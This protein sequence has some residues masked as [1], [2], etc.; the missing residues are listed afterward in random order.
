[1]G[2][3]EEIIKRSQ[4]HLQ[5]LFHN[6][7][8]AFLLLDAERHILAFNPTA[9][10]HMRALSGQELQEGDFIDFFFGEDDLHQVT[11]HLDQALAGENVVEER[12]F[13]GKTGARLWLE[14]SF[15]PVKED[16]APAPFGV[17]LSVVDI[18]ARMRAI[19]ALKEQN[20]KMAR[21]L[22]CSRALAR[23]AEASL[24]GSDRQ[25]ILKSTLGIAGDT[26]AADRAVIYDVDFARGH[27]MPLCEW[28]NPECTQIGRK[29]AEFALDTFKSAVQFMAVT[30]GWMQSHA[31]DPDQRLIDDGAS[32]LLHEEMDIKSLLWYP[33]LF[34]N[35]GF[36]LL[37]L[38]QVRAPR[39]WR[40]L[41][42]E[43]LDACARL[44]RA[45][46][47]RIDTA[48]E[49][50]QSDVTLRENEAR[51]RTIV[52]DQTEMI[53]RH[54][55]DRTITF[56]NEAFCRYFN[57][58]REELIGSAFRP[59]VPSKEQA[60]VDF[61]LAHLDPENPV[62]TVVHQVVL[63]G[64]LRWNQWTNR[65][66]FDAAGTMSE[67]QSVGRDISEQRRAELAL[68]RSEEQFRLLI[69]E[70]PEG[71]FL[72]D[73]AGN[74]VDVN[75]RGCS[76]LGYN[77]E[78]ILAR[79]IRHMVVE[80]DRETVPE[81][82]A[83]VCSGTTVAGERRFLRKDGSILPAEAISKLLPDNRI[84]AILRDI[85]DR[86]RAEEALLES[87]TA[88]EAA[89]EA[90]GQFLAN[91]SHELRTPLTGILG[92]SELLL[93]T[94][95]D[96][97]Q[98]DFT[99]TL[100]DCANNL[101]AIINDVLDFSKIEAGKMEL[102]TVMFDPGVVVEESLYL[103]AE[104]GQ[105]KGV[106]LVCT[107]SPDMPTSL[108]GDPSRL[109]QVLINL[110]GNAIKFTEKGEVEVRVSVEAL[111][112]NRRDPP[113]T[114]K[115]ITLRFAVRDTG[116]GIE[117]QSKLFKAFSQE[118]TSTTRR[119]GGTG[120]G[121]AITKSLVELMGGTISV[122]STPGKGSTFS[123]T[124]QFTIA[125]DSGP[126]PP[127]ELGGKRGLLVINN[128]AQRAALASTLT[129]LGMRVYEAADGARALL[130][131]SSAHAAELKMDF[132]LID[133]HLPDTDGLAL[134]TAMRAQPHAA[135]LPVII[136]TTLAER[137]IEG[138]AIPLVKP[139]KQA[140]LIEALL[141]AVIG[142]PA[143][144]QDFTKTMKLK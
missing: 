64:N 118:D 61:H 98:R 105:A 12:Q 39:D 58:T 74:F 81:Q 143:D 126:Q 16:G 18:S 53:Y 38:N 108:I 94:T 41:E 72:L 82:L 85:S 88:A 69:E 87:K 128:A 101:L 102:E 100:R 139:I 55:P 10:T 68:R 67:Y 110:V 78:E 129:R 47:D 56:V 11:R 2:G 75:E 1:M 63:S 14:L 46:L 138:D 50:A 90:K 130:A 135:G 27:A 141:Q 31:D 6:P 140:R 3:T 79:S 28:L 57:K 22:S 4:A 45:A 13:R 59:E 132:T 76:L 62:S 84:L 107:L 15:S 106:E 96:A 71:I 114:P 77:R 42:L 125:E 113:G 97:D 95:L 134:A 86:K 115:R 131:L 117:A 133:S 32:Q 65:A 124:S 24:T 73:L 104:R 36:S 112:W 29:A 25:S 51:Y 23:L 120:L 80:E 99:V 17:L 26:L 127:R 142:A 119:Y 21:R 35:G 44:V 60:L 111:Q 19:D 20:D 43:F 37:V 103:L 93:D 30:H 5:A 52:E 33:F 48:A 89:N 9:L 40:A 109:R 83:A 136:A 54:R 70:A 122:A 92:M 121:L 137:H 34:R 123:F 49:R 91:M 7:L 8:Q 116:I 66:V 144:L